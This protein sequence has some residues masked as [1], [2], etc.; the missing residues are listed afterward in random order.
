MANA[1]LVASDG[2]PSEGHHPVVQQGGRIAA[3]QAPPDRIRICVSKDARGRRNHSGSGPRR[4][5]AASL[6]MTDV[7]SQIGF[8]AREFRPFAP[9]VF[10]AVVDED[11]VTLDRRSDRY[12]CLPGAAPFLTIADFSIYADPGTLAALQEADLICNEPQG[13]RQPLPPQPTM[14]LLPTGRGVSPSAALRFLA[15]WRDARRLGRTPSI[16]RYLAA[17]PP[18]RKAEPN[19]T[20]IASITTTFQ[21]LLPWAPTQGV[22]LW[23]A[24]V[25]LGMLRR[26]GQS[27]T[28]VFGVRTWP[29]SAHCWLQ[30]GNAVLDDDP[31]RVAAYTPIMAV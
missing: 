18:D 25:L 11:I 26:S 17:L 6:I 19:P 21:A 28:W 14:S 7:S 22:C 2:L 9:G 29:F 20:R 12:G 13:P 24:F 8:P 3:L 16:E 1:R 10:M 23:R 30:V 27:A 15:S 31:E 5:P 4:L